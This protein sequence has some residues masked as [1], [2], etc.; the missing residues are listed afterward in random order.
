MLIKYKGEPL[1][2]TVA[3]GGC[4]SC[5]SRANTGT[6]KYYATERDYF[7]SDGSIRH[8]VAGQPTEIDDDEA[9]KLLDLT[10]TDNKKEYYVFEVV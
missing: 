7:L 6:E 8:F 3:G 9:L 1:T 4:G 5:G 2:R 10:F